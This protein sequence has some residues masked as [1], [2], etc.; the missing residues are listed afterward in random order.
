MSQAFR[1]YTAIHMHAL[2]SSLGSNKPSIYRKLATMATAYTI[3]ITPEN[4]GLWNIKQDQSSAQKASELLQQDLEKHHVYFNDNGFHNHLTHQ[5]LSLYGTGARPEHLKK[6]YDVNKTYQRP[7]MKLHENVVEELKDWETA[8]KC[9]GKGEFYPDFLAFFQREIDERGWEKVL[10]EYMFGG[11]AKSEDMLIRMLAGFLHPIIQLMYGVEWKQPA[12]VAMGL[13]QAAVHHDDLRK[14]LLTS[15]EA[16]KTKSDPMPTIA[17]LLEE[18]KAN[19]KL[20][21]AAKFED[22]RKLH[23]GVFARAWDEI[24]EITSRVRVKPEELEEKTAE[25]YHTAIY[26][27]TSAAFY[28]GKEPKFDFFLMHH[29]NICP[30]FI[31]I[32]SQD[33]IPLESKVRLLEWKVRMDIVQYAARGCPPLSLDNIASYVPKHNEPGAMDELLPRMHNLDEDGHAIKLF[34]AAGLGQTVVEKYDD[35]DWVVI[36]GGLWTKIKHLVVDSVE[37]AGPHWVRSA[38]FGE[39]WGII[40]DQSD[41]VKGVSQKLEQIRL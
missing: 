3:R 29:I 30:I 24:I 27:G 14:F 8:K 1:N 38:G 40:P 12:I 5:L 20:A 25:M 9:V 4:T 36:K 23:D 16:A 6:A 32:N 31:A 7:T 34:R 28:P 19:K 41:N 35:K 15:E 11:D 33:W 37:A 10:S 22:N 21:T 17:S 39:A 18:V 13:A 2:R 26:E